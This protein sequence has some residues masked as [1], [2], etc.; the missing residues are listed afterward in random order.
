MVDRPRIKTKY[1]GVAYREKADGTKQYCVWF[2]GT[3]GRPRWQNTVGGER[4]AVRERARIINDIARGKKVAPTKILFST[5]AHEWLEERTLAP[6]TIEA[7]RSQIDTH[8]IPRL[9][10][11]TKLSEVDVNLVASMIAGMK[12]EGYKAWSI[13]AALTPLSG[14]M[15]TAVRRGLAPA[16]PKAQLERSEMPQGDAARMNILDTDE[17]HLVLAKANEKHRLLLK[18]SVFTGLR[19]SEVLALRWEDIDWAEGVIH[20]RGTKTR[21]ARRDVFLVDF[22]KQELAAKSLESQDELV[23]HSKP[24]T[25]RAALRSALK[26]AGVQKHVRL[27]DLRHTFASILIHQ[28]HPETFIADQM[29]HSS[30]AFT[31]QTYGHLFDGKKQRERA[32]EMMQEAFG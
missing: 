5:F 1:P 13:R 22:L 27:H 23:F 11:Y 3:D 12:K 9:G 10:R 6:K 24:T 32:Q 17:I 29:G 15:N 26:K 4:D 18:T 20:V 21:A 2:K 30:A 31:K 14:I 16:N 7:Y 19:I 28:G 25:V 8:L